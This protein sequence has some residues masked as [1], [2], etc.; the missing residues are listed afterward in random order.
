MKSPYS[1]G[2]FNFYLD[3]C[4]IR[5]YLPNK[6]QESVIAALEELALRLERKKTLLA[7]VQQTFR[8]LKGTENPSEKQGV[9]L[10]GPVGRGKSMLMDLFFQ[11]VPT[12]SK[13]RAHFYSFMQD[14]HRRL[15]ALSNIQTA[16]QPILMTAKELALNERLLCLDEFQVN[17]I[18]DAMILARLFEE[19]F[20][21]GVAV[22]VTS[23][24][25]PDDL[26]SGGL[27]RERFLPF[28]EILKKRMHVIELK[29]EVDYRRE[30]LKQRPRYYS[31]LTVKNNNTI[32]ALFH[33]LIGSKII[34]PFT[35]NFHKRQWTIP[36]TADS[37]AWLEYAD[38]CK[39]AH[40]PGDYLALARAFKTVFVSGIPQ[41][42]AEDINEAKRFMTLIDILYDQKIHLIV[43]AAVPP[44]QLYLEGPYRSIFGRTASRLIEMTGPITKISP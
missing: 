6:N 12:P 24:Q 31:P 26:Y 10:Y 13:R 21:E 23:N 19:L 18:A 39:K 15:K 2:L 38:V 27:Q 5:H 1:G 25:H 32:S 11:F 41:F 34:A 16:D 4:R 43:S 17:D 29:G 40:G 28:I 33:R 9:Y 30:L 20:Q 22:M 44:D 42:N 37:V 3:H 8:F 35:L 14:I 7:A 36:K